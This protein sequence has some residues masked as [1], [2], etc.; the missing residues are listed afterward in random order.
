MGS[1]IKIESDQ[2]LNAYLA[3][4]KG[5]PKGAIIVI[6]EVWGLVD[7]IKSIADRFAEEGYIALAPDLLFQLDFS[8]VD[9]A[10]LQKQLFD[11]KTRS[12]VQPILRGLMTPIQEPTFAEKTTER[13]KSCFNYLYNLADSSKKVAIIGYCFGGT[14][15]YSLAVSEPRLRIAFPFYGHTDDAVEDLR[16]IKCPIRTAFMDKTTRG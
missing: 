2:T 3:K 5:T 8:V 12:E 4:P 9:V 7:H 15:S 6:H 11:P 10:V 1:M 14:Y 16:S 13:T